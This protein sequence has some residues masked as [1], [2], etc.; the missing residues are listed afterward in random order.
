MSGARG[1]F[2][3]GGWHITQYIAI[4][5]LLHQ[6]AGI[7]MYSRT[8]SCVLPKGRHPYLVTCGLEGHVS[9]DC[10]G[11]TKAKSCYKCGLEGHIVRVSLLWRASIYSL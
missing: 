10:T 9:R 11:E 7:Q 1:C 6:C 5:Y 3:C 4:Y 2:N 8:S